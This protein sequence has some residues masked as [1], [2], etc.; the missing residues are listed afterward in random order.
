MKFLSLR[1]T[2][3]RPRGELRGELS[4]SLPRRL[5][6]VAPVR[7]LSLWPPGPSQV[8]LLF[9]KGVARSEAVQAA[10]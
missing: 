4:R 9:L 3:A 2:S 5:A 8:A 7:K 1:Q 6:A 10:S